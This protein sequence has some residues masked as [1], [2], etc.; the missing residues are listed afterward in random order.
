MAD[1]PVLPLTTGGLTLET[2]GGKGMSLSLLAQHGF[3]V[4]PGFVITTSAYH[5]YVATNA[6]GPVIAE[7]VE[8]PPSSEP[9][10]LKGLPPPSVHALL[11]AS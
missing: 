2:A 4:P 10:A 3:P 9:A 11:T 6:L 1:P 7:L 8:A 5:A